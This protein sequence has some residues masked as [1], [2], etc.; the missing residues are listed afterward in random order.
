LRTILLQT[1]ANIYFVVS[2]IYNIGKR[3]TKK[4]F[5]ELQHIKSIELQNHNNSINILN[6]KEYE[7]E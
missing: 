7:Y 4:E 1:V 2:F 3:D 5:I 6:Q